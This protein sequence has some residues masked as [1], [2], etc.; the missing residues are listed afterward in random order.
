MHPAACRVNIVGPLSQGSFEWVIGVEQVDQTARRVIFFGQVQG[1]GFRFTAH[2]V[3]A[4]HGLTGWVRNVR[5]GTVEMVAQ[6]ASQDIDECIRNIED[7]F[8]GYVTQTK[9]DEISPSPQYRDFK[10]T[11]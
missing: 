11:F 4:H 9:I 8:R 1:V 3:A 10:I 5:D 6:G 7:S 2:R